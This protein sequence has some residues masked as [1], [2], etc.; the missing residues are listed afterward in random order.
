VV[1]R[2]R[3]N[4]IGMTP[5]TLERAFE[6]FVQG[7]QGVDRAAGGL[8]LGL[9]IVQSLVQRHGGTVEALS[10]GVGQG[11]EFVVRLPRATQ[12]TTKVVSAVPSAGTTPGGNG[13][14]N[15]RVLVVDDNQDAATLLAEAL[16]L[17]GCQVQVAFDGAVALRLASAASFDLFL[18]D[19]GLPAM[20]GYELAGRLRELGHREGLVALTGYGQPADAQ[21]ALA[22][23]F[24]RHLV[25]PV[26]LNELDGTLRGARS[27]RN[28]S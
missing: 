14:A 2:V 17:R 26:D 3:D 23:G 12:T 27:E 5:G 9:S 8:G 18:L 28:A 24:Q 11:S 15:K 19:I 21:R 13:W 22:A 4:G 7:R 10:E 1:L 25:K 20:D 6:R 16:E